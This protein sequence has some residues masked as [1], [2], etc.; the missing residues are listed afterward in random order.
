MKSHYRSG[1]PL[2]G[3]ENG[4]AGDENVGSG[5]GGKRSRSHI[6][7]SVHFQFASR[8][9]IVDHSAYTPNLRQGTLEKLLM[10]GAG[11]HCHHEHLVELKQNFF[12]HIGR[13][14][15]VDHHSGALTQFLDSAHRTIEIVVASQ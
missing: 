9:E 5:R 3:P 13:R 11:I 15:R 14:R 10:P 6:D 7:T 2:A 4:R 12:K 1:N 8:L